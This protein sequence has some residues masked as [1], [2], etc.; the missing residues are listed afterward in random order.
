MVFSAQNSPHQKH[1][2]K[3]I[4]QR[5]TGHLKYARPLWKKSSSQD[6]APALTQ[7]Q[8]HTCFCKKNIQV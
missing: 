5:H 1:T 4:L 8:A 3:A 6:T 2:P 7:G